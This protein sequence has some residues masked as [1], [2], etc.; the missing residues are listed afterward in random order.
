MDQIKRIAAGLSL[1]Q[2]LSLFVAVALAV[3]GIVWGVQWS[4]ER[5]LKPLFSGLSPE[6]AGAVVEKLKTANVQYKVQENGGAILVPSSRVAEL[7][8]ELAAAG[9]PKTGRLGFELFDKTNFGITEFSEQVNYRRALEGELERSVM[10]LAEVE[11]ARVH[12]TFAKQSVFVESR[13]PAKASVMVKLKPGA[14]LSLQNVMAITHLTA[15]AVEGLSPEQVSVLDMNGN[16]LNKLRKPAAQDAAG[17]SDEMIEYR[18][19]V[20]KDLLTKIHTTLDPLLGQ[21][22]FRVGVSAEC[23]FT[24]GEQS[25]ENFDPG[26]SVM[27][28]SQKS[29]DLAGAGGASGVP[30]TASSL[31][32]PT[33]RPGSSANGMARRTENIAFQTSRTVR[34][35]KIPQG[36][37]K[38]LSVAILVDQALRWEG[39]GAKAKRVLEP[40]SPEKLKIVHDVVAGTVG[41]QQDR[42][43]QILVETLAF[44]ATANAAPPEVEAPKTA[45]PPAGQIA[46]PAW[47]KPITDKVA[48]P[49]LLGVAGGLLLAILGGLAWLFLRKRGKSSKA[50]PAPR[51]SGHV[52]NHVPQLGEAPEQEIQLPNPT[53][54]AEKR[55]LAQLAQAA[56]SRERQETAAL[57]G[58]MIPSATKKAEVLKKHLTEEAKRNPESIA[59]LVRTWLNEEAAKL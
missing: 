37:V 41:F 1:S 30:G 4:K 3:A 51:A 54:D 55:A 7:R 58:L 48:M 19:A 15:S 16:L 12:V 23:D 5:D 34:H 10:A 35:T 36:S 25:E 6:D 2:K 28:T 45:A 8:L 43:D 39:T 50:L 14:Q 22:K 42:G 21:E 33:S 59:Q 29:E 32:R 52:E 27:V 17:Y 20:E 38:R 24:S 11:R 56:A 18:Q 13:E 46:V 26:R 31:P 40:P 53:D 44:E 49:V 57:A 9:L 47:L